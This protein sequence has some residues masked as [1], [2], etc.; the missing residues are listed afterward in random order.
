MKHKQN[1]LQP[2]NLSMGKKNDEI[3]DKILK[4]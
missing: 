1:L 3:Q 2:V 4:L